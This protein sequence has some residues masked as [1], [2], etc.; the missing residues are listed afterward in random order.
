MAM[1]T[2]TAFDTTTLWEAD[3]TALLVATNA[4]K[5]ILTTS[6]QALS[7]SGQ[8]LYGDLTAELTTANGYTVGGVALTGVTLT[9]SGGT[10]SFAFTGPTPLW[11]ASGGN[12]VSRYFVIYV[13]TTLNSHIKPLVGF[14]LMD[15]GAA[16][17]TVSPPGTITING[18]ALQI[19]HTP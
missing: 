12:L 5:G 2:F 15:S 13:N 7:A 8:S 10:T 17:I 9:R 19:T 16:D 14:C 6:A 11:T 18:T 3:P 4:F 1:G